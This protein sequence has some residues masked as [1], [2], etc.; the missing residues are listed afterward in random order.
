MVQLD[1]IYPLF[2]QGCYWSELHQ[3][4]LNQDHIFWWLEFS[5]YSS[6]SS[7]V[8]TVTTAVS[9]FFNRILSSDHD[10]TPSWQTWLQCQMIMHLRFMGFVIWKIIDA[11]LSLYNLLILHDDSSLLF[12]HTFQ[13]VSLVCMIMNHMLRAMCSYRNIH[14]YFS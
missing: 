2:E 4:Q 8:P 14:E 12:A 9:R 3:P 13:C 5:E 1:M 11:L 7:I 6:S 10:L